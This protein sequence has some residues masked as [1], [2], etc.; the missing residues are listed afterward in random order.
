VQVTEV[1]TTDHAYDRTVV[2]LDAPKLYTLK[3]LQSLFRIDSHAQIVIRP[4]P[5]SS[6]D[7]EIRLGNDWANS[8]PMP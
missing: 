5:T 4:D 3:F 2:V 1:G 8:N 7:V 6:A